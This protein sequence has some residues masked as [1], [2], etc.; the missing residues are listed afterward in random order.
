MESIRWQ[1]A[2]IEITRV[3]VAREPENLR[4]LPPER[5][6]GIFPI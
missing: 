5:V 3:S 1:G 2:C 6:E 4:E